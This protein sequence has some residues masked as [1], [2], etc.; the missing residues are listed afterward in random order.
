MTFILQMID[1]LE[2]KENIERRSLNISLLEMARPAR[3]RGE[4]KLLLTDLI[5]P[6]FTIKLC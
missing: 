2:A 3:A 6:K 1:A 5:Q 4:Y